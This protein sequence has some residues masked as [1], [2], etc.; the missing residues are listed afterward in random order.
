MMHIQKYKKYLK[1]QKNELI[2]IDAYADNSI[3]DIIKRLNIDVV[4]ITKSNSLLTN[5]DIIKYN[6]HYN[7]LRVIYNNTYHDRYF[8]IDKKQIYHC[9]TSINII[10]YKTF[11]INLISD[12]DVCNLL[13]SNINKII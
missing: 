6:K 13:I 9:G 10:G 11:S 3:L 4:I 5:Q 8:I 7:N 2:I 1:V 12:E